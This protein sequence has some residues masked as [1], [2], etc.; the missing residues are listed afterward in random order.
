MKR[1]HSIPEIMKVNKVRKFQIYEKHCKFF[2]SYS[3]VFALEKCLKNTKCSDKLSW[4]LWVK[5]VHSISEHMK[6]NKE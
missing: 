5:R 6:P 2:W 1:E 4:L 3:T